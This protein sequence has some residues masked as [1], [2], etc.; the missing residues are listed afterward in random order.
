MHFS[1][2]F[3]NDTKDL[4]KK[5]WGRKKYF[6][7]DGLKYLKKKCLFA[8]TFF[9]ALLTNP[10]EP[11]LNQTK[12]G[13]SKLKVAYIKKWNSIFLFL[14]WLRLLS[15]YLTNHKRDK[16]KKKNNRFFKYSMYQILSYSCKW[17][18]IPHFNKTVEFS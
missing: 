7:L 1:P 18:R 14:L 15:F 5:R 2:L 17:K 16:N 4:L 6:F 9:G 13:F 3:L 12:N 10:F 11:S 8:W